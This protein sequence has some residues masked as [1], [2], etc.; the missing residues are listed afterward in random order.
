MAR[1]AVYPSNQSDT[2]NEL[3]RFHEEG[4]A[5][6][7]R[8]KCSVSRAFSVIMRAAVLPYG[9]VAGVLHRFSSLRHTG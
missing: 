7:S 5:L 6:N 2:G 8:M 3:G 4:A 9:I 1:A